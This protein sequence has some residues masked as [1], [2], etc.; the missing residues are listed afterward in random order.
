MIGGFVLLGWMASLL[1]AVKASRRAGPAPLTHLNNTSP[2][3]APA[4]LVSLIVFV[5]ADILMVAGLT[6][7]TLQ[8]FLER[9]MSRAA[10]RSPRTQRALPEY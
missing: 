4:L 9:T 7:L 10:V 6:F 5:V 8:W 3:V 1:V 2:A